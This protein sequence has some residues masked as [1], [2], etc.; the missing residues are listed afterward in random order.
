MDN[1]CWL[2]LFSVLEW[3]V[4][5]VVVTNITMSR[6]LVQYIIGSKSSGNLSNIYF[7][8]PHLGGSIG[9]LIKNRLQSF[10]LYF[11][12]PGNRS[13]YLTG[14][15]LPLTGH[16]FLI[17]WGND[18]VF[19]QMPFNSFFL[20]VS[21]LTFFTCYVSILSAITSFKQN[22]SFCLVRWHLIINILA[23]INQ[24]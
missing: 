18:V 17:A 8:F 19:L 4:E 12:A 7:L 24:F 16:A 20:H 1:L 14:E 21:G 11:F 22:T 15:L 23:A 2:L 5:N 9:T 3:W 10:I 6:R 13:M